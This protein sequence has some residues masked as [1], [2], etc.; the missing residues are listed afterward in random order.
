M[1]LGGGSPLDAAKVV[2]SIINK[3]E[4]AKDLTLKAVN[5]SRELPL[6]LIP[7]TTGTGSEITPIS[8]LTDFENGVKSSIIN[9][10]L[11]PDAAFLYGEMTLTMPKKYNC[12]YRYRCLMSQYRSILI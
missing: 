5:I 8:I 1:E 10:E 6:I 9:K 2:S 3:N 12:Y 4:T 11:I 7:T